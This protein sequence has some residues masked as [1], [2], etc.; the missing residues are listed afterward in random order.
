MSEKGVH[1]ATTLSMFM[2]L[3][4][5]RVNVTVRVC[6]S[7]RPLLRYIGLFCQALLACMPEFYVRVVSRVHF[8]RHHSDI[9]V[10]LLEGTDEL[11]PPAMQ[12]HHG[13]HHPPRRR[14]GEN[15]RPQPV[16]PR[17]D[18]AELE[19]LREPVPRRL[20]LDIAHRRNGSG[21]IRHVTPPHEAAVEQHG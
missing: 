20:R 8:V 9:H 18:E 2:G 14:E 17:H 13:P 4:C 6:V 3:R 12:L 21:G 1:C 15:A 19:K 7:G 5:V 16:G 11:V 10:Y